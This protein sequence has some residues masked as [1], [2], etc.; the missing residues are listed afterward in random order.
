MLAMP[1][2][3][4]SLPLCERVSVNSSTSL[5]VR[6]V[7]NNPTKATLSAVGQTICSV[8]QLNGTVNGV[9][10]GRPAAIVPSP[11]TLGTARCPVITIAVTTTIAIS[12]A[13]TAVVNRGAS[14]TI[15]TVSAN[16]G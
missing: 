3:Q 4:D 7:S 11:A 2:A 1:S 10:D 14:S 13:G 5:A 12:G 15:A 16:S 6:S 8:S 9:I